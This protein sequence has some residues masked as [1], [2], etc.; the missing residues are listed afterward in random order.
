M[1]VLTTL[2]E[3]YKIANAT[4]N[5]AAVVFTENDI[6]ESALERANL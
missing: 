4:S 5:S 3:N 2:M 6:P 1:S